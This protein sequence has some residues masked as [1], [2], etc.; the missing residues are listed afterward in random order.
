MTAAEADPLP[1]SLGEAIKGLYKYW[2]GELPG[3]YREEF[4]NELVALLNETGWNVEYKDGMIVDL[5]PNSNELERTFI[6]ENN[7][8]LDMYP[9]AYDACGCTANGMP[10]LLT[11][12]CINSLK[13]APDP[14][15]RIGGENQLSSEKASLPTTLSS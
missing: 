5:N 12:D 2:F 4:A 15:G 11:P 3:I 10:P 6:K 8:L 9:S 7:A 13:P 1:G 14:T